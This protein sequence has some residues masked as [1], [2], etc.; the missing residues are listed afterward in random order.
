V[1]QARWQQLEYLDVPTL[2]EYLKLEFKELLPSGP[3]AAQVTLDGSPDD[4][5]AAMSAEVAEA[6][7]KQRRS[8]AFERILN[9]FVLL[10]FLV[11]LLLG[12]F[13]ASWY[14]DHTLLCCA[15]FCGYARACMRVC[16][17]QKN[18]RERG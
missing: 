14:G 12:G 2:R 1:V 16:E 15:S 10:T 18:H 9:D 4:S 17:K 13:A 8:E 5:Q 6:E 7:L 3:D 11:R